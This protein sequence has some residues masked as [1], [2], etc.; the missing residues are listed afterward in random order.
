MEQEISLLD[1]LAAAVRKGTKI[2]IFAVI[3]GLLF[4]GYS[5]L[6]AKAPKNEE[7]QAYA[8]AEKERELRDLQK[9]VERAEMGID[10]ER[11]YIR[12]SLYM[13]LNPYNISNTRINYQ[14]TDLNVPLDGSLGM[15]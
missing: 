7:E 5:Y 8:M 15:M 2:I 14:L 13:Q 1:L 10:A 11:E 9:T 3:V 4:V 12:D 6:G